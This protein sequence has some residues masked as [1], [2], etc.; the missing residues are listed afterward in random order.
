[1]DL[2][3]TAFFVNMSLAAYKLMGYPIKMF[4]FPT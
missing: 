1:M 3:I 4:E 2:L